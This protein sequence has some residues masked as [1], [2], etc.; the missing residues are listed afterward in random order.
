MRAV[1]LCFTLI[2]YFYNVLRFDS[3]QNSPSSDGVLSM[4]SKDDLTFN[5]LAFAKD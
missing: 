2:Q 4:C 5:V 1:L 3:W